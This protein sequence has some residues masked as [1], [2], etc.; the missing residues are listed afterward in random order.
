MW[1]D[2]HPFNWLQTSPYPTL[3]LPQNARDFRHVSVT[4]FT[5]YIEQKISV[6]R[7]RREYNEKLLECADFEETW[8]SQIYDTRGC[9]DFFLFL[10][11]LC[12]M[13][14]HVSWHQL[15]LYQHMLISRYFKHCFMHCHILYAIAIWAWCLSIGSCIDLKFGFV[16]CQLTIWTM[17]RAFRRACNMTMLLGCLPNLNT[18]AG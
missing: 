9:S 12:N 2:H 6:W 11:C 5:Q 7:L 1:L 10:Q 15:S 4:Y 13:A 3:D 18:M 17:F 14:K 8:K 16:W